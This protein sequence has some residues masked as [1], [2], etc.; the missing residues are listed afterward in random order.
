MWWT[1]GTDVRGRSAADAAFAFALAGSSNN[2]LFTTLSEVTQLE[3]ARVG[4]RSSFRPKYILQIVEKL[5]SAGLKDDDVRGVHL[6]AARCLAL[7]KEYHDVALTLSKHDNR[8]DLLSPRSLFWLWRFSSRLCKSKEIKDEV[9]EF[10]NSPLKEPRTWHR[11]QNK[12][13]WE[14]FE[15][16]SLPL[17]LDIGSG[18]GVSLLG[19]ASLSLA[20]QIDFD[21][22]REAQVIGNIDFAKCNYLGADLNALGIGYARG[23]AERWH[24]RGRLQYVHLAAEKMLDEIT[25]CYPGQVALILIQFPTPFRFQ[26]KATGNTQLPSWTDKGSNGFMA[27]QSLMKQIASLMHSSNGRLVVQSNV[28]DVAVVMQDVLVNQ[29]GMDCLA[30]PR[31]VLGAGQVTRLPL[32]TQQWLAQGGERAVGIHWSSKPFLPPRAATET[33]AACLLQGTPIHRCMFRTRRHIE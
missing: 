4:P 31:P 5:A 2:D 10:Y 11:D 29:V 30:A 22:S 7:K 12:R 24:L 13:W 15:D 23:I 16:P 8:F 20:E 21:L 33:E 28:E 6:E 26:D 1:L 27:S 17:V 19:L 25:R 3:L 9:S 14:S 32:R 18:F